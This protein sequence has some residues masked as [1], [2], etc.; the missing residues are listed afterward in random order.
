V[1]ADIRIE[2]QYFDMF[3]KET[4]LTGS[5]N[6]NKNVRNTNDTLSLHKVRF[7]NGGFFSNMLYFLLGVCKSYPNGGFYKRHKCE[8]GQQKG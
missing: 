5:K 3:R 1:N 7:K 8:W 4:T 2:K 6:I